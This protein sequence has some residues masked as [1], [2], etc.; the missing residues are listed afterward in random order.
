MSQSPE[1]EGGSREDYV[2]G[3]VALSQLISEGASFSG[4][5]AHCCFL[6]TGEASFADISAVSGLNLRDDGRAIGL[7]DWDFDGALDL[8]FA[9]RT[10]PRLRFM[11]NQVANANHFIAFRLQG[12]QC[13]RDAIGARIEIQLAKKA[14][15]RRIRTLHAGESF[16]SQSSKW[17]HFGLGK[18]EAIEQVSV[19]WP[20][21]EKEVFRPLTAD[22]HYLLVQGTGAAKEWTPP[23]TSD[24]ATVSDKA[25]RPRDSDLPMQ[26]VILHGRV[27]M[28]AIRYSNLLTESKTTLDTSD[29]AVLIS[30]WSTTCPPC[31]KELKE[32][33]QAAQ[34]FRGSQLKFLALNVDPKSSRS[35]ARATLK[36]VKW[37]HSAGFADETLIQT[38]DI[39]QR[40]VLGKRSQMPLPTS[41][42]LDQNGS[43]AAIYMGALTPEQ[44][45]A[46]W[47][48][49]RQV[50]SNGETTQGLPF[51]G[52][53]RQ[54]PGTRSAT[55]TSIIFEFLNAGHIDVAKNY[56][57]SMRSGGSQ[58]AT[59]SLANAHVHLAVQMT[60]KN[61]PAEAIDSF[62]TALKL[63]PTRG[64]VHLTLAKLLKQHKQ[65]NEAFKHFQQAVKAQ[66][67][68]AE[69]HME[70]GMIY[71]GKADADHALFHLR[72]AMEHR[73]N[74]IDPINVMARVLAMHPDPKIKDLAAASR[75][76]KRAVEISQ[77][78][79]LQSLETLGVVY[80]ASRDFA[81]A[82]EATEL[83]L[84][85]AV[86]Q[87]NTRHVSALRK[88]IA[89]FR[90]M[91]Q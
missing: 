75:L 90:K 19:H 28:P 39:V 45:T 22:K 83:A 8:W 18:E 54:A 9:N 7:V 5:E 11:R 80:A 24:L 50:E 42:L 58:V 56:L 13:N 62:R 73:P 51:A 15:D 64:E 48:K 34:G 37:P 68:N 44:L 85:I 4:N 57:A 21:G 91:S 74:W 20:G 88:R 10:G 25:K 70:L 60:E 2:Y 6:N 29:S 36:R 77:G 32:F 52:W 1:T 53:W 46:D 61:R 76:A 31:L 66:P 38:L 84:A 55:L 78:A 30:L 72:K 23:T 67:D 89:T 17:V 69:A 65:F 14:S 27:P 33:S 26:R 41:F 40:I 63:D 71:V 16:L 86:K 79:D 49:L 87:N 81:K 12:V 47:K 82:A 35:T 59:K 3:W 43:L